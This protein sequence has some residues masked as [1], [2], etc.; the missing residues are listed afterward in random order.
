MR[1]SFLDKFRAQPKPGQGGGYVLVSDDGYGKRVYRD[2]DPRTGILSQMIREAD[3]TIKHNRWQNVDALGDFAKMAR[4]NFKPHSGKAMQQQC[5]IPALQH[6]EIMKRC[7]W[8]PGTS[9][10]D[11][12]QKKFDQ[13]INDSNEAVIKTRP[14]RISVRYNTWY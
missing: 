6:A 4:D 11:Y 14:G 5:I 13:I 9:M 7:G 3:G 10:A 8:K 1:D 2:Y 12:D